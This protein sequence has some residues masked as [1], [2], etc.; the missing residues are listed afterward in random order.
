MLW[1]CCVHT[2]VW[3]I[4]PYIATNLACK[5]LPDFYSI[6]GMAIKMNK[7]TIIENIIRLT[8]LI[9]LFSS[10]P[11][12]FW[13]TGLPS[14]I[15]SLSLNGRSVSMSCGCNYN[16]KILTLLRFFCNVFFNH[17]SCN[18][19]K[20]RHIQFTLFF[21][22]WR[23]FTFGALCSSDITPSR[24]CRRFS[25]RSMASNPGI[26]V[27]TISTIFFMTGDRFSGT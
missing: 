14:S 7:K 17:F 23:M 25:D 18:G 22:R 10:V 3:L 21:A 15:S 4:S 2:N 24:L 16:D 11:M 12:V 5:D 9:Y 19:P 13:I 20:I 1:N 27:P 8:H 6:K 26:F